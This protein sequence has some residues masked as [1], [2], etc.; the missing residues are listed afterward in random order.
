VSAR[1]GSASNCREG[2]GELPLGPST[3]DGLP[4]FASLGGEHG[5]GDAGTPPADVPAK[6]HKESK[7]CQFRVQLASLFTV[8]GLPG[9]APLM[10]APPDGDS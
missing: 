1:A 4:L 8:N 9:A 5:V 2:P 6:Q 10:I 3:V 7:I